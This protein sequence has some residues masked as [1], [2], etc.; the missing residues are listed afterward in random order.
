[1]DADENLAFSWTAYVSDE[2]PA[3][4][5]Q[6]DTFIVYIGCRDV[7]LTAADQDAVRRDQ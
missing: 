2:P 5:D 1:V 4:E 7:Q 6:V 3:A